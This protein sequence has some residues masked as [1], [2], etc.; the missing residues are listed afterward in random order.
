MFRYAYTLMKKGVVLFWL[1]KKDKRN[2]RVFLLHSQANTVDNESTKNTMTIGTIK[3][4]TG[5]QKMPKQ[6]SGNFEASVPSDLYAERSL[7]S[8]CIRLFCIIKQLH[9][10][11]KKFCTATNKT[12]GDYAGVAPRTIGKYLKLLREAGFLSVRLEVKGDGAE[13]KFYRFLHV[14]NDRIDTCREI[15]RNFDDKE[16]TKRI[17]DFEND[18]NADCE[19]QN[20]ARDAD[21]GEEI[22]SFEA[23]KGVQQGELIPPETECRR[24]TELAVTEEPMDVF[25]RTL[26]K[27]P[28]TKDII[29]ER[30]SNKAMSFKRWCK[31]TGNGKRREVCDLLRTKYRDMADARKRDGLNWNALE[32][33]LNATSKR[34]E[35]DWNKAGGHISAFA[36][37]TPRGVTVLNRTTTRT[38]AQVTASTATGVTDAKVATETVSETATV[39]GGDNLH[40]RD[41]YQKGTLPRDWV[42]IAV[43]KKLSDLNLSKGIIDSWRKIT[44]WKFCPKELK[45][46]VAALY[47]E[48][49]RNNI[50]FERITAPGYEEKVQKAI[51]ENAEYFATIIGNLDGDW[52][53]KVVQIAKDDF[54][55]KHNYTKEERDTF[56]TLCLADGTSLFRKSEEECV[57]PPAEWM[58]GIFPYADW[59][60][61]NS[62]RIIANQN[63]NDLYRFISRMAIKIADGD[64]L[65]EKKRAVAEIRQSE[66]KT[67]SG[68]ISEA[69][70]EKKEQKCNTVLVKIGED[71]KFYPTD[72]D[73]QKHT[74]PK[75]WFGFLKK[76]AKNYE[77]KSG[78]IDTVRDTTDWGKFP[79]EMMSFLRMAFRATKGGLSC[80]GT[81]AEFRM[82]NLY[83]MAEEENAAQGV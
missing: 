24:V 75:F 70:P 22:V 39:L 77:T 32:V 16:N 26:W 73:F 13:R 28:E 33:F 36:N 50:Y 66:I 27:H 15:A 57:K 62:K 23:K 34:W 20:E 37:T 47:D 51:V 82:K 44:N 2:D 53:W 6:L 71:K 72:D 7:P 41:D 4:Q 79:K 48:G 40:L 5:K 81:W 78:L 80:I 25:E 30:G 8:D 3:K 10:P 19:E 64:L 29:K 14:S 11:Q 9:H 76:Y 31:L 54:D 1:V 42:T 21:T 59:L 67:L 49:F 63:S 18:E 56:D 38:A 58:K 52:W 74:K 43:E 61:E 45:Q 55:R 69:F 12:L 17:E 35:T 68:V 60:R 65:P 83:L 46:A